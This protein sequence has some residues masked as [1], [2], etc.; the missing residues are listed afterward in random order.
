MGIVRS[1]GRGI[2]RLAQLL[3]FL[4]GIVVIYLAI[5]ATVILIQ[6]GHTHI[7]LAWVVGIVPGF[8]LPFFTTLRWLYLGCWVGAPVLAGIA[9]LS[10]EAVGAKQARKTVAVR[11]SERVSLPPRLL[12]SWD[13]SSHQFMSQTVPARGFVEAL[14]KG[15]QLIY[16]EIQEPYPSDLWQSISSTST[17]GWELFDRDKGPLPGAPGSIGAVADEESGNMRL[18]LTTNQMLFFVVTD[19]VTTEQLEAWASFVEA[20]GVKFDR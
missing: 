4:D 13:D 5:D 8:I 10:D 15:L 1:A 12:A 6:H 2:S 14:P 11:R 17:V 20:Q 19:P 3:L 16:T 7:W 18:N 9:A